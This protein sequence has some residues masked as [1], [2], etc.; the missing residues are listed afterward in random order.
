MNYEVI[1]PNPW[2]ILPF[3]LLLGAMAL[4]P[5]LAAKWWLR[6]Y[7]KVSLGLGAITLGYYFLGLQASARV[8]HTSHDYISFIAL[9]GSLFV[10]PVAFTSASRA[11][12][13]HRPTSFF[14]SSARSLPTSWARPV[15][16]CC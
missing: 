12:P 14:C 4:A 11:K 2:M 10:V 6:H 9:I 5:L 13:R 16:Q 7:T 1:A 15:R 8:W 3:A